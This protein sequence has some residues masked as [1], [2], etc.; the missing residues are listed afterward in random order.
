MGWLTQIVDRPLAYNGFWADVELATVSIRV[1]RGWWQSK[2]GRVYSF[3][4]GSNMHC[5]V[6]LAILV[7]VGPISDCLDGGTQADSI[8]GTPVSLMPRSRASR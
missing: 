6:G 5:S 1:V 2:P 8:V 3:V 4:A 7:K